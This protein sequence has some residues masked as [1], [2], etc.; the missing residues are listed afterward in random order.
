MVA[1]DDM[2]ALRVKS[3][4]CCAKKMCL[5]WIAAQWM[6]GGNECFLLVDVWHLSVL[7][8]F[9]H[10]TTSSKSLS[11]SAN[12]VHVYWKQMIWVVYSLCQPY[13]DEK[14]IKYFG[15]I[16]FFRSGVKAKFFWN[17]LCCD[18]C[19][20]QKSFESLLATKKV[21][22]VAKVELQKK[23]LANQKSAGSK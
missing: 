13:D 11:S 14:D 18:S 16:R 17:L 12:A 6:K 1:K 10:G 5:C 3:K 15:P 22:S 21:Y 23:Y 20:H 2:C 8:K 9:H 7:V 4:G 19:E